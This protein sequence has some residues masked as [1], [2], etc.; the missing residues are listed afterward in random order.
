MAEKIEIAK[1]RFFLDDA[2]VAVDVGRPRHP[3][4]ERGD[5]GRAA[6]LFELARPR[7]VFLEG[8]QIDGA[9]ALGERHHLLEDPA[10]R[11]AVEIVRLEELGRLVER[12]VVDENGA[13]NRALGLEVVWQR[14][15]GSNGIG[16]GGDVSVSLRA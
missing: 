14:A 2:R 5:V 12:L 16:H 4:D 8:D 3:V 15:L 6:N 9:A 1:R 13:Q 10:M 7:E 11:V